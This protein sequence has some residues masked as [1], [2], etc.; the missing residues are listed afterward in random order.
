MGKSETCTLFLSL[1]M[2]QELSLSPVWGG[3]GKMV[4]LPGRGADGSWEVLV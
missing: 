1:G 3:I 2:R 4:G